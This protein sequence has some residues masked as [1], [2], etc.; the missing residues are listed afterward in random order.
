MTFMMRPS[1]SSPTGTEIGFAGVGHFGAAHEALGGVHGDGAHGVF[2]EVLRHFEH[3]PAA[4]V[5]GLERVENRRQVIVER[6]VHHGAD[7]LRYA[8]GFLVSHLPVLGHRA[9]LLRSR[10]S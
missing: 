1:V 9:Y 2:A 6:H 3:Q 4:V 8:T 10:R 5:D 7:D